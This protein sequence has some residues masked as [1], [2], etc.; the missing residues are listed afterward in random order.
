MD[1]SDLLNS[2]INEDEGV[3]KAA[4]AAKQRVAEGMEAVKGALDEATTAIVPTTLGIAG[5]FKVTPQKIV[6]LARNPKNLSPS[7]G[8]S[9]V[10]DAQKA[11]RIGELDTSQKLATSTEQD[12]SDVNQQVNTILQRGQQRLASQAAD[13]EDFL[14][15]IE[16]SGLRSEYGTLLTAEQDAARATQQGTG[17]VVSAFQGEADDEFG[18][19]LGSQSLQEPTTIQQTVQTNQQTVETEESQ[20]SPEAQTAESETGLTA[21]ETGQ[22]GDLVDA[23]KAAG[24][25]LSEGASAIEAGEAGDLL[26]GAEGVSAALDATGA[27]APVG[28]V[29]G[30]VSFLGTEVASAVEGF[31][32]HHETDNVNINTQNMTQM[33][34]DPTS[35]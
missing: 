12:L 14:N 8:Y 16:G 17:N 31:K 18:G 33:A 29:L 2:V 3:A 32:A 35:T 28:V 22:L 13:T 27:L 25:T 9:S 20:S 19:L 21:D 11:G 6:D 26:A 10:Q 7:E 30:I 4:L 15:E 23:A 34:F 1:Y 24:S 5:A